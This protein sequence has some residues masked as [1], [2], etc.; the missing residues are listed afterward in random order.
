MRPRIL[1][2]ARGKS[3]GKPAAGRTSNASAVDHPLTRWRRDRGLSQRAAAKGA[4]VSQQLWSTCENGHVPRPDEMARIVAFTG[5]ALSPNDFYLE[6][7]PV[8][9]RQD[10]QPQ[11]ERGG[12]GEGRGKSHRKRPQDG[13]ENAGQVRDQE[14]DARAHGRI[15]TPGGREKVNGGARGSRGAGRQTVRDA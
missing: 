9:A 14:R 8:D 1:T 6:R 2:S 7:P 12:D 4:K 3:D 13:G 11:A 10:E 15:L 5:D